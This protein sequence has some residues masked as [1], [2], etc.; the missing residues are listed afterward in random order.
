LDETRLHPDVYLRNNWAV[1][2]AFDALERED[3]KSQ[4]AAAIKALRDVMEN[5]QREVERLYHATREEWEKHY[6]SQFNGMDWDPRKDVPSDLWRDKVEELDLNAFANMIEENGH[7][8]WHSHLEMIKWEFRLPFTDPRKPMQQLSCEKLF[9]L[10]TGETDQSL[11]PGK[12][13]TG[14]VIRNGDFGSRVKLE[15]DIPAFISV[16]NLADVFVEDGSA[17]DYV[18]AGQVI[19]AVVTEVKKD[20]MTVDMSLKMEDFR[21]NPSSWERPSSLF[22]LD[23][24]FDVNAAKQIED[25]S[26]KKREAHIEA[27]QASLG[28]KMDEEVGTGGT[29]TKRV[30][31]VVRRACTHPAFRNAKNDE[32]DKELKS[33]G[34]AMVGEALIRPSSKSS[35]SLA[36]HWLYADGKTKVV[37]VLE[38]DKETEASIGNKLK[39]KVSCS[40]LVAVFNFLLGYLFRT[41]IIG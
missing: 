18:H 32:V 20:H 11:R 29:K 35:D 8:K 38:E 22:P 40:M 4:N 31:R 7:G 9:R 27:L 26:A 5:S 10:I 34:P 19:T 41:S 30:G 36:I 21:R 3:S 37:E 14:K 6:G 39:I 33:G 13:V 17:D 23:D 2:I 1:K 12:E 25:E 28:T 16:R 24:F 15:G